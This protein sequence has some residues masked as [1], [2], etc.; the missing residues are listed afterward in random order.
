MVEKDF[1]Q[2]LFSLGLPVASREQMTRELGTKQKWAFLQQHQQKQKEDKKN[3]NVTRTVEFFV[4]A[5]SQ[6]T[7][8]VAVLRDLS[9]CLNSESIDWLEKFANAQGPMLVF[10]NVTRVEKSDQPNHPLLREL[11]RCGKNKEPKE[12]EK[13]VLTF[14]F[15]SAFFAEG[16]K[17]AERRFAAADSVSGSQEQRRRYSRARHGLH[18]V[19]DS[20]ASRVLRRGVGGAGVLQVLQA[21]ARAVLQPRHRV[22]RRCS[23]AQGRLSP[24]HQ[25]NNRNQVVVVLFPCFFSTL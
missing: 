24:L 10:G 25:H 17:R 11:V 18:V 3:S 7:V 4:A 22:P 6:Q 23:R 15:G 14:F 1:E 9:V 13:M 20:L 21:R 2:L 8:D 16:A 12:G 19:S 5:V